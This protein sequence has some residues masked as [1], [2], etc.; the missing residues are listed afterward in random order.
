MCI[1]TSATSHEG[2][3]QKVKICLKA[4]C[5]GAHLCR[6]YGAFFFIG[7]FLVVYMA[8]FRVS[9]PGSPWVGVLSA[10]AAAPVPLR[11]TQAQPGPATLPGILITSGLQPSRYH[12]AETWHVAQMGLK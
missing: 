10:A 8:V 4:T 12:G 3:Y 6:H 2:L 7:V 5:L 11:G 9:S 1:I